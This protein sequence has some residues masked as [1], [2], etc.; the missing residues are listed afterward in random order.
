MN[1][2]FAVFFP[3]W[4]LL[5][6]PLL[7]GV[8]HLLATVRYVPRLPSRRFLTSI[9]SAFVLIALVRIA[10]GDGEWMRHHPGGLETLLAVAAALTWASR[11][12]FNGV[13]AVPALLA[14]L[15]LTV[16]SFTRPLETIGFLILA[17]NFVAFFYWIKHA[18]SGRDRAVAYGALAAFSALTAMIFA[19]VFDAWIPSHAFE[20]LGGALSAD[21][22]GSQI[23]PW[24]ADAAVWTR[25]VCAYAFG[26]GVHY[27]VWMKAIPEQDLK[28]E[29][30]LSFRGSWRQL[31]HS[32]GGYVLSAAAVL[33]I[34]LLVYAAFTGW[35]EARLLYFSLAAFHGY[36][37][38]AGLF[39][40]AKSA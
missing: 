19:G 18:S 17:H 9:G 1:L 32:F 28:F 10:I 7:L 22:I 26:Q 3:L 2:A 38:I 13:R 5:L 21:T 6:G 4:A 31:R 30:S 20:I 39:A 25:A 12:Y 34:G 36:F 27:F 16:A 11:G 8:P 15:A 37:E 40:S 33:S 23:L 35:P 14:I 24:S 29:H